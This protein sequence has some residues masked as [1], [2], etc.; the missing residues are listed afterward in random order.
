MAFC[1][2]R[3]RDYQVPRGIRFRQQMPRSFVGKVLRRQLIEEEIAAMEA[4]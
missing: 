3:L 2:D 1:R 4:E